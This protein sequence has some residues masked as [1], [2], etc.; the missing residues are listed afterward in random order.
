M[1]ELCSHKGFKDAYERVPVYRKMGG[2]I[3]A[4]EGG[5][6]VRVG[7]TFDITPTRAKIYMFVPDKIKRRRHRR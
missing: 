5:F 2:Q 1:E 6:N 7:D 3:V 4:V